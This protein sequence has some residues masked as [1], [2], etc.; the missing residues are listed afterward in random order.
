MLRLKALIRSG[1]LLC[2]LILLMAIS[3]CTPGGADTTPTLADSG[4]PTT[5]PVIVTPPSGSPS[6]EVT[7]NAPCTIQPQSGLTAYKR[8]STQA[9]VFAD[10]P[11]GM[12]L[13][14]LGMTETGW[15]GFDPGTAQAANIGPFRLRWLPP[16]GSYELDG[17]CA[18]LTVYPSLPAGVCFTMAMGVQPIYASANEASEPR[19]QLEPGDYVGVISRSPDDWL[20]LDVNSG[21]RQ[22]QGTAWMPGQYANFNGPCSALF[23]ALN[24][25]PIERFPSGTSPDIVEIKMVDGQQGWAVAGRMGEDQHILR[26]GDAGLSWVDITPAE[27][28]SVNESGRKQVSAAFHA[29][30]TARVAFYYSD[31]NIAPLLISLWT[32]NDW[33]ASW[34]SGGV[35]RVSDLAELPPILSFDEGGD[36]WLWIEQFVGMG[37]H[38]YTLLSSQDGGQNYHTLLDVEDTND[39]CHRTKIIRFDQ[40]YGWLTAECPFLG[41]DGAAVQVT[42]DGGVSWNFV[43]LPTPPVPVI[44]RKDSVTCGSVDVQAFSRQS[45]I[46]LVRCERVADQQQAS[47]LYRTQDTGLSWSITPIPATRFTFLDPDHGWALGKQ[48]FWTEDG[49]STWSAVKTVS[50]DGEFSFADENLGWAVARSD[51]ELALVR[52]TDGGRTW[53]LLEPVI[54]TAP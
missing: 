6:P 52:T 18:N 51:D 16:E 46:I 14:A 27:F 17:D 50:W 47:F 7:S 21:S 1:S 19:T 2:M 42:S 3:G 20:E 37:T 10:V 22:E 9:E 8:P 30:G 36:G 53:T 33:G 49:G 5:P 25:S 39:T 29:D 15:I 13:T 28:A 40:D 45:T 12:T 35:R 26:T 24:T 32:T 44:W 38:G 48:I 31:F 41:V 23:P 43:P 54:A 34:Q 4:S 11:T